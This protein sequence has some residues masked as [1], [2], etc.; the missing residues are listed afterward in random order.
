MRG[1]EFVRRCMVYLQLGLVST[2][3]SQDPPV[4][5]PM[6]VRQSVQ[7]KMNI[8]PTTVNFHEQL[9]A[10]LLQDLISPPLALEY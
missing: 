10:A 7:V 9:P 5:T 6:L 4:L 2:K 3:P 1:I 8:S